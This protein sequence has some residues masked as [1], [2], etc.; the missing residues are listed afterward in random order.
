MRDAV[1]IWRFCALDIDRLLFFLLG[2][3]V[4][5][6]A[7]FL[8]RSKPEAERNDYILPLQKAATE[9]GEE[10]ATKKG[11]VVRRLVGEIRGIGEGS[12]DREIE[13]VFNLLAALVLQNFA[14]AEGDA[15][16]SELLGK[17]CEALTKDESSEKSVVRYR[18]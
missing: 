3:Q 10:D 16:R 4:V 6:V 2:C 9:A 1:C 5:E 7:A 18:M 13:G 14:G 15:A 8:S 17:L 11:E 12:Q